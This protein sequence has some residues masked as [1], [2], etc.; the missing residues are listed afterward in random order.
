MLFE[1]NSAEETQKIASDFIK[2][3]GAP[4]QVIV[5]RGDL[6]AGKTQFAK[7][8]ADALGIEEEITSPT[9]ALAQEYAVNFAKH[10]IQ[11][12]YHQ[13]LCDE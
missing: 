9:F 1:S 7:G 2:K 3:L 12:L 6:G 10:G 13:V 5:L 11:F 4:G 8:V